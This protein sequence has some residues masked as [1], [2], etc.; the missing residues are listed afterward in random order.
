MGCH[1]LAPCRPT[2]PPVQ[3]HRHPKAMQLLFTCL[4]FLRC[5]HL[6]AK[7]GEGG[8]SG[9]AGGKGSR[10]AAAA[11]AAAESPPSLQEVEGWRK[12]YWL[13]LDYLEL[14]EAAVKCSA[15]FT[16]LL[17]IEYWCEATYGRLQLEPTEGAG[18][19]TGGGGRGGGG[20]GGGGG[21]RRADTLLLDV[22]SQINEPDSIYAVARSHTLLSQ[23]RLPSAAGGGV[24][25]GTVGSK[26]SACGQDSGLTAP[27]IPDTL[28]LS[29]PRP[30]RPMCS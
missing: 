26:E 9:K 7:M 30:V 14:A 29:S 18:T 17:Y 15:H 25:R 4:N 23:V 22:Y 10:A 13:D 2:S 24:G 21:T 11:A 12:V 1:L 20:G 3:G 27:L 6:D 8:D 19:N 16:A 28:C 5:Q